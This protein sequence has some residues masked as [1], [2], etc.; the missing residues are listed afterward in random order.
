MR[1]IGC[2]SPVTDG[3]LR[4]LG[5]DPTTQGA[6]IRGRIG[7]V[8]QEDNLDT[9]LTVRDNLLIYGRYFDLP[10]PGHPGA[11]RAS[12]SSSCSWPTAPTAWSSRCRAA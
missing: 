5:L 2:V 10:A 11:G 3:D 4:V 7:V 9:E 1:M 12:C 8:S 6:Q